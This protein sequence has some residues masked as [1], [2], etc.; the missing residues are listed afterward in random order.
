M[1]EATGVFFKFGRGDWKF[2]SFTRKSVV[3]IASIDICSTNTFHSFVDESLMFKQPSKSSRWNF[4]RR[5]ALDCYGAHI[6][7]AHIPWQLVSLWSD[8]IVNF[9]SL[10]K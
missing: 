6:M 5:D 9:M 7:G 2:R 3:S 8:M 10:F 1:F 4:S